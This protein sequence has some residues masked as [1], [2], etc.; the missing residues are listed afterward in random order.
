[1]DDKLYLFTSQ[2][3]ILGAD[4][5]K[6]I[7]PT[8][9]TLKPHSVELSYARDIVR[10][11]LDGGDGFSIIQDPAMG[12][13]IGIFSSSDLQ[14]MDARYGTITGVGAEIIEVSAAFEDEHSG[15]PVLGLDQSVIG[16]ASYVRE[17]RDHVMKKGTRFENTTRRFC[18]RLDRVK[19]Q[20]VSWKRYNQ[21]FGTLYLES[22]LLIDSIIEILNEWS[23][24][25]FKDVQ[26]DSDTERALI[27][28]ADSHNH[29]LKNYGGKGSFNRKFLSDY[30]AST[31]ELAEVCRSRARKIRMISGQRGLSQ[32]ML[33]EYDMQAGTL[34][35]FG[36]MIDRISTSTDY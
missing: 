31:H 22:N 26:L 11:E 32:F 9:R 21:Q 30:S 12:S 19:W 6:F 34:E 17:S 5:I 35:F 20:S 15:S 3:L 29:V 2:H 24:E 13:S 25:P 8:G 7:S 33:N 4:K 16:I 18:Y 14:D 28:W 27:S 36:K 23:D 1:M 10:L